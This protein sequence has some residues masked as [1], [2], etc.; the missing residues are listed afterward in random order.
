[1]EPANGFTG[2]AGAGATGAVA[3]ISISF[4]LGISGFSAFTKGLV[5]LSCS[6]VAKS[7]PSPDLKNLSLAEFSLPL[8]LLNSG[9]ASLEGACDLGADAGLSNVPPS[10]GKTGSFEAGA[11]L[12]ASGIGAEAG[13]SVFSCAESGLKAEMEESNSKLS[14]SSLRLSLKLSAPESNLLVPA[15]TSSACFSIF[16]F[17][18]F[19]LSATD[20]VLS[21]GLNCTAKEESTKS[22]LFSGPLTPLILLKSSGSLGISLISFLILIYSIVTLLS[23]QSIYLCYDYLSF[24]SVYNTIIVLT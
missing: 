17:V 20:S 1:M 9:I 15:L 7:S 10:L 19:N 16:S 11:G 8:M 22:S 14:N 18:S 23:F 3:G 5:F 4:G 13:F 12:E 21:P 24:H 6:D 2:F